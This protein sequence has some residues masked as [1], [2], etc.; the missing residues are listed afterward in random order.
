MVL[1]N[2]HNDLCLKCGDK[3]ILMFNKNSGARRVF[4]SS[5]TTLILLFLLSFALSQTCL[6]FSAS[7]CIRCASG[8]QLVA[9]GCVSMSGTTS[10]PILVFTDIPG[11]Q[12]KLYSVSNAILTSNSTHQSQQ[13]QTL[14]NKFQVVK[15]NT[16]APGNYY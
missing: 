14:V 12:N 9:G 6:Q 5:K 16:S 3:L 13:Q 1:R 4:Y 11:V 2:S 10:I 7:E 15:V 8:Y